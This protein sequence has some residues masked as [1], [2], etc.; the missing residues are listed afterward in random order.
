[1]PHAQHYSMLTNFGST[2]T[3]SDS[4]PFL[5]TLFCGMVHNLYLMKHLFLCFRLS[6]F[7]PF[8]FVVLSKF[9]VRFMYTSSMDSL[10]SLSNCLSTS[11]LHF[12][13]GPHPGTD[14]CQSKPQSR[15]RIALIL[16]LILFIILLLMETI[17]PI[18]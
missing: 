9:Y 8:I 10:F 3:L 14:F 2:I 7:F 13:S 5:M 16:L 18:Y 1:M 4:Q 12:P 11:S 17:S 6:C 15:G